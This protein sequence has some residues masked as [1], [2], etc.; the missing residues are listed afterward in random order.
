[1]SCHVISCH[2]MSF[3]VMS[4]H[5]MSCHFMSCHVMSCHVISCHVISCHVISCHVMSCHAMSCHVMSCHVMSCYVMLCKTTFKPSFYYFSAFHDVSVYPQKELPF[6]ILFSAA[7]CAF[8]ALVALLTH[9]FPD[10]MAKAAH[11]VSK[12]LISFIE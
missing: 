9:Q 1:M 3:H 5:V 6:F 8:S 2:V 11:L 12:S 7:L 10:P 4:C